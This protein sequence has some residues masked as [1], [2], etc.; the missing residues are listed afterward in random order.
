[1]TASLLGCIPVILQDLRCQAL[2]TLMA[3]SDR[4]TPQMLSWDWEW[5]RALAGAGHTAF[6][7]DRAQPQVLCG[8]GRAPKGGQSCT[9]LCSSRPATRDQPLAAMPGLRDSS[10]RAF[11]GAQPILAAGSEKALLNAQLKHMEP[12]LPKSCRPQVA[13]AIGWEGWAPHWT[14]GDMWPLLSLREA[15][16]HTLLIF[17]RTMTAERDKPSSAR[18]QQLTSGYLH[19]GLLFHHCLLLG[20]SFHL[21]AYTHQKASTV[22]H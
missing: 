8:K 4:P 22:E 11:P 10:L 12:H 19:P 15:H 18:Y 1:M 3:A 5:A 6:L 7:K 17:R 20:D 2:V 9:Q 13:A 21:P 16:A 14:C